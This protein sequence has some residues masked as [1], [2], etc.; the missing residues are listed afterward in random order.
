MSILDFCPAGWHLYDSQAELLKNIEA[1]WDKT[2]VFCVTASTAFG[3]TLIGYTLAKWAAS[4]G[5]ETNYLVPDNMLLKQALDNHGGF[6]PL[7]RKNT[8]ECINLE[9]DLDCTCAYVTALKAIKSAPVR[10]MN[11]WTYL[12]NRRYA[13][14]P[15]AIFDEG[16]KVINMLHHFQDLKLWRSEY[17]FPLT[18]K[19]V[20]DVVEWGQAKLAKKPDEKL[21]EA[22][23]RISLVNPQ[24]EVV[25]HKQKFRGRQDTLLSIIPCSLIPSTRYLWPSHKVQKLVFMSATIGEQDMKELGLNRKRVT[26]I[27]CPSSIPT[28]NRPLVFRP[29][30]NMSYSCST[31]ALPKLAVE[32]ESLLSQHS[33]KGIIHLPYRLALELRSHVKNPRLLFHNKRNKTKIIDA[34]RT[35]A[36]QEG[37]VLVASGLY[38]GIDLKYDEA[39][40]QLIGTIPFASLGDAWIKK[41]SEGDKPWY[42][43]QAIKLLI[44]AYGR[45][46]RTPQDY[47]KTYILDSRFGWLLKEYRYMFP[48]FIL[49]ALEVVKHDKP[50]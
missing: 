50:A 20:G 34:F 4:R 46:T 35:S 48:D 38:E 13:Y 40:W 45:I 42:V 25:L 5:Q 3:K 21:E 29:A 7:H 8:Y 37:K 23:R 2:D 17:N 10:A 39:R 43:W 33:D 19:S 18:F 11:Y 14:A 41:R 44:Q 22:I 12:S 27:E 32:I 26:Y 6:V 36:A 49:E 9:H 1:D 31:H 28:A 16:H 24:N 15:V 47:G 30:Y